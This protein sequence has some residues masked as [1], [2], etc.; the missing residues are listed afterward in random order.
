MR[1]KLKPSSQG[2]KWL[3]RIV[4]GENTGFDLEMIKRAVI[5]M[6]AIYY[7]YF[8]NAGNILLYI[9]FH[10]PVT[11]NWLDRRFPL[12][13]YERVR[14]KRAKYRDT[15]ALEAEEND[16]IFSEWLIK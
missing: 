6:P 15:M 12:E 2:R 1:L 16:W 14:G 7:C 11:V 13:D 9:E 5:D 8:Y 4:L 3:L 10:R